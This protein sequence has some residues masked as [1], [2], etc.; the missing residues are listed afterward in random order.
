MKPM[1]PMLLR[2]ALVLLVGYAGL[3]LVVYLTQARLVYF[4]GP[5]PGA[6]PDALGLPFRELALETSDGVRLSAW[7]LPAADAHGA[8]LVSHGNA[9]S[10]EHRIDLAQ[11]FR[12][13]G[14]SVLL[15][16]YRGYGA[17]AGKPGEDGTY[18]DA[19]AAYDHLAA[20][21]GLAPARIVLYGE[22]LGA[23]VAF[24]LARRRPVAAVIAESAFTSVPELGAEVYPFLP[25]RL[26]ARIRYDNLAKIGELGVPL[27]LIHSPQDEI[28]P[29]SHGQRLFEAAREPK[30][31]LLTGGGHNDGGFRVRAQWRAE[32]GRFLDEV[33]ARSTSPDQR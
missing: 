8:V 16:D 33:R 10:I 19:E 18:R 32:V 22:S 1:G 14:W 31:L 9:G 29:V 2:L 30:Q 28:V 23:A 15:Y 21:E 13:H 5:P 26:L 12:E 7:F 17:S 11:A 25:V 20:V 6:T 4:P 24:E 3:C 27:L